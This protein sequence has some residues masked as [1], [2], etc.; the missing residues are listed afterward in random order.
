MEHAVSNRRQFE[1]NVAAILVAGFLTLPSLVLAA[2]GADPDTASPQRI[3]AST[4]TAVREAAPDAPQLRSYVAL[5]EPRRLSDLAGNDER[6][7]N[8]ARSVRAPRL[9]KK[10]P[11]H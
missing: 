1:A 11:I 6:A 8:S 9:F 5:D 3:V 7:W 10:K 2:G 4:N